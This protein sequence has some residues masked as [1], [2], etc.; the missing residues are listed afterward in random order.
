MKKIFFSNFLGINVKLLDNLG[1]L[2]V[3]SDKFD[4]YFIYKLVKDNKEKLLN[5]YDIR[6]IDNFTKNMIISIDMDIS[7]IDIGNINMKNLI[8]FVV[9][10][11]KINETSLVKKLIDLINEYQLERGQ[12][13]NYYLVQKLV[14]GVNNINVLDTLIDLMGENVFIESFN[15]MAK[16]NNYPLGSIKNFL[17]S[18]V[19]LENYDLL[20]K[21]IQILK[22]T[23]YEDNSKIIYIILQ[24]IKK[25]IRLKRNDRILRYI[26]VISEMSVGTSVKSGNRNSNRINL[27]RF[28]K[29]IKEIEEL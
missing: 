4:V 20:I 2:Q 17:E 9:D 15:K 13:F 1:Y 14:S 16:Y 10:L 5:N 7:P 18:F 25:A 12:S 28:N 27:E 21:I 22:D 29:V 11:A 3:L 24:N 6:M 23:D 19:K 8:N 26:D